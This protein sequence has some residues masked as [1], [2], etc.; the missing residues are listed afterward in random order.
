MNPLW[1]C[2]E[3]WLTS[4]YCT[5]YDC[6]NDLLPFLMVEVIL[7]CSSSRN[8]ANKSFMWCCIAWFQIVA[9]S[10]LKQSWLV[11]FLLSMHEWVDVWVRDSLRLFFFFFFFFCLKQWHP[12]FSSL[13]GS[14]GLLI[15]QKVSHWHKPHTAQLLNTKKK[16]QLR[17]IFWC[18]CIWN[19]KIC[20]II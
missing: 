10:I 15:D 3:G 17:W 9:P 7:K 6:C 1:T 11:S 13:A 18:T 8:H 12:L 14:L 20:G 2:W 4:V 5:G 16:S 19:A